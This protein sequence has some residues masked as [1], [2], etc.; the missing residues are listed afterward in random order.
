MPERVGDG[1]IQLAGVEE[2]LTDLEHAAALLEDTSN[3]V[4]YEQG[5][6][7]AMKSIAHSVLHMA[8]GHVDGIDPTAVRVLCVAWERQSTELRKAG[9]ATSADVVL[10]CSAELRHLLDGKS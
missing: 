3:A 8:R 4:D 7:F 5:T 9:D 1:H 2:T 10:M 6:A